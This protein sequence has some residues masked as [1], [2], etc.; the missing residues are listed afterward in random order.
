M[1][2]SW[3]LKLYNSF[4]IGFLESTENL[5]QFQKKKK[6]KKNK[7]NRSSISEVID[8]EGHSYLNAWKF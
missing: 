3:K 7:S 8:S 1:K 2:L 6:K 5:E 4:F